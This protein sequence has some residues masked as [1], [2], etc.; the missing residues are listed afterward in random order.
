MRRPGGE[1]RALVHMRGEDAALRRDVQLY[2]H[3]PAHVAPAAR[4][5]GEAGLGA[6]RFADPGDEARLDEHLRTV[7]DTEHRLAARG[8][9]TY[10]IDDVV[11]CGDHARAHAVLI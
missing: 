7:A 9:L 5:A 3:V 10:G 8:T 2:V 4:V 1:H 6:H 11:V